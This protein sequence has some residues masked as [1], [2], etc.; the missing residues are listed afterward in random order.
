MNTD[1]FWSAI[2][3]I[4]GILSLAFMLF[5]EYPRIKK[6]LKESQSTIQKF[7]QGISIIF[8]FIGAVLFTTSMF[9][10]KDGYLRDNFLI[11][12]GRVSLFLVFGAFGLFFLGESF[13][14]QSKSKSKTFQWIYLIFGLI[15]MVI[16]TYYLILILRA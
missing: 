4:T 6:R 16:S 3:G 15:Q 8:I 2:S 13:P 11:Q 5:I 10:L 12:Q 9:S 1:L 7:V 14:A